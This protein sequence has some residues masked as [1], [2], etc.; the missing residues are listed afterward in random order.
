[1]EAGPAAVVKLT[2]YYTTTWYVYTPCKTLL[3]IIA[4]LLLIQI[5]IG[6]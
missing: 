1:M 6:M 4:D 3:L 5:P 2:I